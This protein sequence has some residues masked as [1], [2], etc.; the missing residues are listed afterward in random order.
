[1]LSACESAQSD[2][3]V[4]PDELIGLPTAFLQLGARAVVGALWPIP[5]LPTSLLMGRF[6]RHLADDGLT[7]SEALRRAQNWLRAATASE[8]SAVL[9]GGPDDALL[10]AAARILGRQYAPGD[11][12]FAAPSVWAA[13]VSFGAS[14]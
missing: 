14:V 9:A 3:E 10:R 6:Y 7:A 5:D 12:P 11:R 4:L 1:V 13:F 2:T 8:L